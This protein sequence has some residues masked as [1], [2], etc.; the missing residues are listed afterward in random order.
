MCRNSIL[1]SVRGVKSWDVFMD[2]C[3][4]LNYNWT[5]R[6]GCSHR[7]WAL[8]QKFMYNF[9]PL[10][11]IMWLEMVLINFWRKMSSFQNVQTWSAS[12]FSVCI[13]SIVNADVPMADTKL[14]FMITMVLASFRE[15]WMEFLTTMWC[16]AYHISRKRNIWV[17]TLV[18]SV[19]V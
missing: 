14:L 12:P 4:E 13:N 8:W 10:I 19:Q 5:F 7:I 2:N 1:I 16:R 15:H 9:A 17:A 18:V 6:W 3:L 11:S